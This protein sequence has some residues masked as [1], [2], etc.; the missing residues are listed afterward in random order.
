MKKVLLLSAVA[1]SMLLHADVI[2]GKMEKSL[3]LTGAGRLYVVNGE[4]K[5][6]WSLDKC[7]NIHRAYRRGDWVYYS[8]S[9]IHRYNVKTKER[10]LFY[11]PCEKEGVFGFELLPS[12]AMVLAENGTDKITELDVDTKKKCVSF[13]A[14]SRNKEGKIS[15]KHHHFRMIRKTP[16][17]TYVVACSGANIVRE[18]DKNGKLLWEQETPQLAFDVLRRKNGNTLISHLNAVTEYT[19]DHKIAWSFSCDD[20]P[21]LKLSNICGIQE[22]ENGNLVLGTYANCKDDYSQVTALEITRDKKVVWTYSASK[23]RSNMS[24]FLV[25]EWK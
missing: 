9:N 24:A 5:T 18:Y 11:S 12:G 6:V 10:E 23:D 2:K 17:G 3:L 21:E 25:D 4:G 20:K 15:N 14:N 19:P 7:G 13:D 22:L 1:L 8:N 16:N